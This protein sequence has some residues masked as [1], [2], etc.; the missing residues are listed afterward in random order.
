MTE[1]LA[2]YRKQNKVFTLNIMTH[3]E[4]RLE[5]V[6]ANVPIQSPNNSILPLSPAGWAPPQTGLHLA[7][8]LLERKK[9][10]T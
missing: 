2:T 4:V 6:F 10:V 8:N 3:S 9:L 1:A 5:E 7:L